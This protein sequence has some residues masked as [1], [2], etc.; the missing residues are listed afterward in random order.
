MIANICNMQIGPQHLTTI[1]IHIIKENT[2]THTFVVVYVKIFIQKKQ[3]VY[4]FRLYQSMLWTDNST[5]GAE[6]LL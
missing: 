4:F 1:T 3:N 5:C 6:H 2:D